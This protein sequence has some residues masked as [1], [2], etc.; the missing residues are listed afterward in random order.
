M[1]G[2]VPGQRRGV[3]AHFDLIRHSAGGDVNAADGAA[4]RD[5][6]LVHYGAVRS[7]F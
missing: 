2:F 1:A 7:L 6:A 5:A 4:G 3:Q